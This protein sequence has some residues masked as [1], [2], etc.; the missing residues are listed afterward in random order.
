M[1]SCVFVTFPFG[2]LGRAWYLVVSI[3]DL[4]LFPYFDGTEIVGCFTLIVFQVSCDCL[5][6]KA[7]CSSAVCVYG[8]S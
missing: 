2:V 1:F 7:V 8:I 3:P 4:S 6:H 5:C